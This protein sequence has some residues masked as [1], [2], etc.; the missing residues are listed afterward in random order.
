MAHLKHYGQAA[1]Q[2]FVTQPALTRRIQ[3]LEADIGVPLFR[4]AGRHVELTAAGAALLS[5]V[6]KTLAQMENARAAARRAAGA[7]VGRLSIG[8]DGAAS[9]SLIPRLVR[10]TRAAWPQIHLDFVEFS[11]LDQMREIHFHRLDVGLVRPLPHDFDLELECVFREPLAL[12]V[13]V[14]HRLAGRRRIDLTDVSGEPFVAY[15]ER[16]SY[17]RDLIGAELNAAGAEPHVVQRMSRT[18]SILSLVSTGLGL[19]IV[20]AGS[21]AAA[22]D[23]IVFKPLPITA[24]AEWHAARHIRPSN[25][26]SA[27]MLDLLAKANDANY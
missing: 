4:R 1:S 2:L 18:H 16:G 14:G 27:Q 6:E 11:S 7:L 26:L 3:L 20:P 17:L 10:L 21:A 12:A 24:Q 23:N 8:F 13:P 22:F 9:Y 25:D 19:A 15:S 5:E